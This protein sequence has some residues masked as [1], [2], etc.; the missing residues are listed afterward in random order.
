MTNLITS[1]R[2]PRFVLAELRRLQSAGHAI[3]V[4]FGAGVDSTAMLGALHEA[5]ITPDLILFGDTGGEKPETYE[6][7]RTMDAHLARFG[8]PSVTWVK[9]NTKA[10]TSYNDLGGNCLDNETLPSLAFGM[11]SCSIKWKHQPQDQFLKGVKR[12]PN[13]QD[14]HPIWTNSQ[15]TGRKI[16]KLIGYDNGPADLRRSKNLKTEDKD[17]LYIYPLQ[18]LGWARGD[19]IEAIQ[20][21]RLPVPVKSACYFCPA[22]KQWEMWWLAGTH[23]ELFED[24]LRI[25][26]TAMLGKHSRYQVGVGVNWW[27][28]EMIDEK[29]LVVRF[30]DHWMKTVQ[31]A[32][33]F[34]SSKT[35]VGLGRS[36][37]WLQFAITNGI[38]DRDTHRVHREHLDFFVELADE[39]R[40]SD[41]ALDRRTCGGGIA[42]AVA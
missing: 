1:D 23:P 31:E 25:E 8:F 29:G 26:M 17:F 5:D 2:H 28:G 40:G 18:L 12:G 15:A 22:S 20:R 36:I 7:A 11:K 27:G 3:Q 42:Q 35:T 41:N 34:P 9:Y 4:C 21:N 24:A 14:P 10:D 19:C 38:V 37:S 13:K 39:L 30:G 6:H 32:D 33:S 16:I